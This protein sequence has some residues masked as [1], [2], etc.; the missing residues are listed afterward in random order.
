M[1]TAQEILDQTNELAREFYSLRGY[2][3][4]EGFR[5]DIERINTHPDEMLCWKQAC[6]AQ[7]LLTDTD[8]GDVLSELGE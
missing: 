7:L 8:I 3:V 2:I 4:E 5:F 6:A 1:R